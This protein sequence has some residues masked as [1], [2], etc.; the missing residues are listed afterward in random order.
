M[1]TMKSA[2]FGMI[3]LAIAVLAPASA[4]A[5]GVWTDGNYYAACPANATNTRL[6]AD[7]GTGWESGFYPYGSFTAIPLVKAYVYGGNVMACVYAIEPTIRFES[8][9]VPPAGYNRCTMYS[10]PWFICTP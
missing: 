9:L 3:S 6:T 1:K 2:L 10:Y 7:Q 8:H 5:G 4:S